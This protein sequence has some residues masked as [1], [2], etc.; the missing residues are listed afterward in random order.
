MKMKYLLAFVTAS[1]LFLLIAVIYRA[2]HPAGE[3]LNY[4]VSNVTV[5]EISRTEK[6][7][8][9][10]MHKEVLVGHH[11]LVTGLVKDSEQKIYTIYPATLIFGFD[12]AKCDTN[13]IKVFGDSVVVTLPPVEI[14]NKDGKAVDE[15]NKRTAIEVGEW[16]PV[17]MKNM[18]NRA[19]AIMRRKCEY[20]SCYRK[21]ERMG[22]AVVTNAMRGLGYQ[23]VVVNIKPRANYG[24]C[25]MGKSMARVEFYEDSHM[26]FLA[27]NAGSKGQSRLYYNGRNITLSELL[28]MADAM[29]PFFE[30][31]F[32]HA[33]VVKTNQEVTVML[34]NDLAASAVKKEVAPQTI[35]T[36]RD[37]LSK[38]V[39]GGK[40][41][42]HF[43]E[44][45]KNKK[46]VIDY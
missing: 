1:F 12:L 31:N 23:H 39:F 45:D 8:V 14:L 19:E 35:A 22:R 32:R 6:L 24:L 34:H 11:R 46:R 2:L 37:R 9:L 41:N 33:T 38:Q 4:E 18:K 42:V 15:A 30:K 17:V 28:A 5:R 7:K 36:L 13:S 43:Q 3:I 20:D 26:T 29:A 25:L 27:F 21:A 16:P 10:S 40:C 44:V